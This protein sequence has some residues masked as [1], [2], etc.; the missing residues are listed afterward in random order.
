MKLYHLLG[1]ATAFGLL[2]N[3]GVA[4]ADVT[5][6]HA[7][8][9]R[10]TKFKQPL[11]KMKLFTSWTAQRNRVLLKYDLGG[12]EQAGVN[13]GDMVAERLPKAKAAAAANIGGVALA[14]RLDDDRLLAYSTASRSYINEAFT[15]LMQKLRFDPWQKLDPNLSR[16]PPP[17]FTEEQR[18]RL[19]AEVR[20]SMNPLTKMVM[21]LY[22]RPLSNPKT[23]DGIE[24]HGYRLTALVN[25]G[26]VKPKQQQ[27]MRL[28]E[29]FWLAS[30]L[31]GDDAIR[32]F[33]QAARAPERRALWKSTS[34]WVNEFW[35]VVW[36]TMPQEV[37]DAVET[38]VPP[39]SSPN[40]GFGGTP[41]RIYYSAIFPPM[42]R[43]EVGDIREEIS[44]THRSTDTI[45]AT[46]FDTPTGY[47]QIKLD[48]YLKQYQDLMQGK[49]P[50]MKTFSDFS[51]Q[52]G[53]SGEALKQYAAAVR[54]QVPL[55]LH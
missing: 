16:T 52:L 39:A 47:K 43:S 35:P 15:P 44:L 24:T 55:A 18:K 11:V 7:M 45:A 17:D 12:L 29:E 25:V 19:G 31:P 20:A 2:G 46:V 4:R 38:L 1:T 40:A 42:Q 48:P 49:L 5:W 30:D 50:G 26:G 51:E 10:V 41:V 33:Q 27:W 13:V 32:T 23:I 34:M 28:N 37:I 6:E 36:R 14:Q 21:K 9:L 8:T 53:F 54:S 22:F 3:A